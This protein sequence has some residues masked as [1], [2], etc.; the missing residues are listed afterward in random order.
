MAEIDFLP[1]ATG[2][3]ANVDNQTDWTANTLVTN[4]FQSGILLS[5]ML[6]KALRQGTMGTAVL[7]NLISRI[8]GQN[9]LDNGN[10]YNL[11]GQLW[12]TLLQVDSFV[13]SGAANSIYILSP[14]N[15]TFP[16]PV[17]G[18]KITVQVG[19]TNT[20]AT[21]INWM[22][23]GNMPVTTQAKAALTAGALLGGSYYTFVF[24][25]TEWQL[26]A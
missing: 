18:L 14:N 8:T 1:F 15:L 13:D 7:A 2:T 17:K 23:S 3:N 6:N 10:I 16:A 25:G 21:S 4:G 19:V 20:G 11:I 9:V 24:D 5:A 26:L 22:D 12:Q